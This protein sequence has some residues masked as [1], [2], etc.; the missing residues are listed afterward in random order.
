MEKEMSQIVIKATFILFVLLE[1]ICI[2]SSFS[3]QP[4]SVSWKTHAAFKPPDC[5]NSYRLIVQQQQNLL[6][7]RLGRCAASQCSENEVGVTVE[8][9]ASELAVDDTISLVYT[10]PHGLFKETN[11]LMYVGGFN[12][13]DGEEDPFTMPLIPDEAQPG[14][15]KVSLNIPNFAKVMDFIFTDGV[16]YD[17]NNGEYYHLRVKHVR[18]VSEN[19]DI[20]L[21]TQDNEGNLI[22]EGVIP[23]IDPQELEKMIDQEMGSVQKNLKQDTLLT[24]E[25]EVASQ[26]KIAEASILGEDL[27]LGNMEVGEARNTFSMFSVND[28]MSLEGLSNALNYLGFEV[29]QKQQEELINSHKPSNSMDTEYISLAEFMHIYADL[30]LNNVG[31]EIV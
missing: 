30:D 10:P 17:T 9:G 20:I 24:P 16:R 14:K 19:G 31:L 28:K 7:H 22:Q 18:E 1:N 26:Q 25:A 6:L 12:G 13:W 2:I 29:P 21:Y 8:G 11:E 23:K 5:K 3:I 15:F 4:V 27:G